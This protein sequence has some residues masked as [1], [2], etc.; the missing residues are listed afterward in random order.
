MG[1]DAMGI[2]TRDTTEEEV[3]GDEEGQ[4]DGKELVRFTST[5]MEV[6][7]VDVMA[8]K[9]DTRAAGVDGWK[10]KVCCFAYRI[11]PDTEGQL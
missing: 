10:F 4:K 6:E 7:A 1:S 8:R 2:P 9:K 5:G 11:I 3:E